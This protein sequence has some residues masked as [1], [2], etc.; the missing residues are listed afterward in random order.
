MPQKMLVGDKD[1]VL[2]IPAFEINGVPQ[3]ALPSTGAAVPITAPTV[4]LMN[5]FINA[6]TPA[7][8]GAHWGGN[9]TCAVI[10]DWN[11]GLKDSSTKN[12]R[13]LCSVGN[14][15]ELTFYNFDAVMNFL[16]DVDPFDTTSEFNLPIILTSAPDVAYLV[17]HRVGYSRTTAAAI[18][19]EWHLYYSW[20][21]HA[22]P[23][24]ADD[25]Y[26]QVGETFIPKGVINFKYE[27]AA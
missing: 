26:Q 17:A 15:E 18:G 20:T 11:V 8:T 5:Y 6:T 3:A 24:S 27:L 4:A 2:L 25:D 23:A 10:D 16:R 22:I 13:T 12:V 14:S 19:Q 21:D 7:D 9:V 1:T